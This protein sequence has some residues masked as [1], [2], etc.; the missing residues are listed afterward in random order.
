MDIGLLNFIASES[1]AGRD[2]RVYG[3]DKI[4]IPMFPY[5]NLYLC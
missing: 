4:Y 3:Y 2:Y 1:S 5:T